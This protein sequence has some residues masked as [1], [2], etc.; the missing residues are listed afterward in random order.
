M[1]KQRPI[2]K[3]NQQFVRA[4]ELWD[5]GEAR[6]AFH[7]FLL[8]AKAGDGG[9]QLNLGYFYDVGIAVKK[10]IPKAFYWYRRAL[11]QGEGCAARN[12]GTIYRD[13]NR[14]NLALR[15]FNRAAEL[16]DDDAFLEIG[17]IYL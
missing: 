6:R 10:N 16:R 1:D 4:C 7:L 8:A 2:N 15:W 12:I 13:Q 17:K 14:I 5:Q 9:A 11:K 3:S